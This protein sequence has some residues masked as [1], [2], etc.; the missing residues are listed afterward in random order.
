MKA[1]GVFEG[2]GARGYA[3]IGA[4]RAA[5]DRGIEFVAVAGTSFGAAIAALVAA[6]YTGRE[7]LTAADATAPESGLFAQDLEQQLLN[8]REYKRIRRVHTLWRWMA[9]TGGKWVPGALPFISRYLYAAWWLT[10]VL[11]PFVFLFHGRLLRSVWSRSGATGTERIRA[12]LNDRLGHRL[13]KPPG[14]LVTFA[15]LKIKLRVVAADLSGGDILVFGGPEHREMEV[16]EAVAASLSY[17]LFFRPVRIGESIHVDGGIVSNFPA[18]VLDD[19]R[20]EQ[21][22]TYP[23]FGFRLLD[24]TPEEM[25]PGDGPPAFLA[26]ARRLLRA[27]LN[28]RQSLES[29]R[30]DDYHPI[31]L[32]THIGTLEFHRL[33]QERTE[34]ARR[35]QEGVEQYFKEHLGPR[36]P[37][38]MGV[39][40]RGFASLALE[41]LKGIGIVRSYLIQRIGQQQVCRVVYSALMEG[42]ADDAL[43]IRWESNSQALC[44]R[45]REPVLMR[46]REIPQQDFTQPATKYLHALRPKSVRHVYCVPIFDDPREWRRPNPMER[47]EPLAALCVDFSDPDAD[48]LLLLDPDVEDW[49][50]AMAQAAGEFWSE[51]RVLTGIPE[52]PDPAPPASP[53]WRQIEGTAGYFVSDRKVRGPLHE[54]DAQKLK[55]LLLTIETRTRAIQNGGS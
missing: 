43:L 16:A 48:D 40:L 28:S 8:R 55:D 51:D 1:Y 53:D 14:A 33:N 39:A 24:S 15:D 29:R 52:L 27:A 7:L 54:E 6:G 35:G 36:A 11:S 19:V 5:E 9:T 2:G 38:V 31:T 13:G 50:A 34:L 46:V 23:T 26:F 41:V 30:I 25:R 47:R 20:E 37:E 21:V 44:L 32:P 18:W 12:W 4:L 49:M 3:H 10:V 17:P 42:D 45:L 22:R